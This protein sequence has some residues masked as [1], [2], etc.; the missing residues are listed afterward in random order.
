MPI[1]ET[2]TAVQTCGWLG[3]LAALLT[4]VIA[5][6]AALIAYQQWRTANAR[7]KFDLFELRVARFGA[8]M[9]FIEKIG[10]SGDCNFNE[11]RAVIHSAKDMQ[12]VFNDAIADYVQDKLVAKGSRLATLSRQLDSNLDNEERKALAEEMGALIKWFYF[13][14]RKEFQ[15]LTSSY[16]SLAPDR[17]SVV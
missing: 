5:I 14:A 2:H 13:D 4:P 10:S 12:W 7:L 15:E 3:G 16:L 17:K 6:T 9:S 11:V 8:I 1:Q